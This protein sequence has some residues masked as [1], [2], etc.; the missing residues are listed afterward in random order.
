MYAADPY[1][2]AHGAAA[3]VIVTEWLVYRNPDFERLRT[4]MTGHVLVDGRNL[5]D[6][7]RMR[8]FGFQYS[9]IGRP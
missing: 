7:A 1:A 6:P 4:E 2:A 8:A 3:L 5:Y 9:S